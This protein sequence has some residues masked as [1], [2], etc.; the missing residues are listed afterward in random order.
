MEQKQGFMWYVSF[1]WPFAPC[2]YWYNITWN[3]I[4]TNPLL[5]FQVVEEIQ[6]SSE[7]AIRIVQV[8]I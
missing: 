5:L 1:Q 6:I 7:D 3:D 8:R 4:V 2:F